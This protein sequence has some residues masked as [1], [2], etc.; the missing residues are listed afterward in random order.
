MTARTFADKPTGP[1]SGIRILDLTSV[2]NGAYGTQILADQG[3]DVIKLEDPG[4]GRGDGG[5]IMRWAGHL[6]EGAPKGMGPI[7]LTINRNKR[8]IL[9]DLKSPAGKRALTKII[10]GCDVIASSVRYEGM[11][12]LGLAYEDVAAIK[13]DIVFVHAAGYGS[14][15]P[16]A[17]EPAYDDLIQSAS[18]MA[19]ILPRTDGDPTPR[20]LPTLVADKV[21]GLFLSQAVTA[22]LLHRART[23]EGQF[24]EVP[25]FECVT[26]FL[27]VEHLYDHTFQPPTGQWGYQRVVN[28]NRKPFKTK[29]G[30]IGLLPYTDKQWDQFFD[31]AGFGEQVKS[32]PRFADYATRAK[33]TR[34]LYGM[35]EQA[36]ATKTTQEWLDILKPLSIPVVKTNQLDDLPDDPHLKAVE[37]FQTY[38]HPD[39]GAYRLMKPPVKFARTPSNLRRH[40]PKLGEHTDEV[41]AEFGIDLGEG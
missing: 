12:R 3:A 32:D 29:D 34:E 39:V 25:M 13:P 20:I 38:A 2:V 27:L 35:I 30:Y 16:Y 18:G 33:H 36:A 17:G 41:M 22:A 10:K 15:G 14:D 8:S 24:V 11:K 7:F 21:S 9:L 19:D 5:D 6:P 4:S 28:P 23:G 40:P 37:F 31:A 1:L 26:S